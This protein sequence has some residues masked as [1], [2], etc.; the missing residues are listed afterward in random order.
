MVGALPTHIHSVNGEL[1]PKNAVDLV[2]CQ[3]LPKKA[4]YRRHL[5]HSLSEKTTLA[6]GII[7][8]DSELSAL[9]STCPVQNTNETSYHG[10]SPKRQQS[11][12]T[13]NIINC[14]V[15]IA[16]STVPPTPQRI[17]KDRRSIGATRLRAKWNSISV[18]I[19]HRSPE[20][21]T[22]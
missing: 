8:L 19:F 18:G 15:F 2:A 13:E 20:K 9:A 6:A 7:P 14:K 12:P 17:A 16:P 21:V 1:Y 5:P 10:S 22:E 3:D 11:P 4:E